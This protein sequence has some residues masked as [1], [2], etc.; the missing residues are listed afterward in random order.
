MKKIFTILC[1]MLLATGAFAELGYNATL[2][3]NDFNNSKTV[4]KKQGTIEWDGDHVRCGGSSNGI[5]LG[6]PSWDWDDKYFDVKIAN[7][8]PNKLTFEWAC[9]NVTSTQAD[10]YVKESADGT[11]WSAAIWETTSSTF[12]WTSVSKDLQPNTRY[13]R[14]CFSGNFAGNFRNIKVTEKILMGTPNPTALD[15]GTVKVDDEAALS[16]TLGWTNLTAT[17]TGTTDQFT[18]TP[19]NFG[20]IGA[21]TQ[22]ATISVALNTSAAGEYSTT[23]HVEGRGKSADVPVTAK[24]EKY[25]QTINWDAAASYNYGEA[26][27]VAVATSGLDVVYEISDASVLKFENGAFVALHGG[28]ATVTAKQAGNYKYNA[29]ADVVKT[30]T[31]V[32]PTT[33]GDFEQTT[34]DEAVEFKNQTY[35]ESFSGEVPVGENYLGGDSIVHVNIVINHATFGTD[36]MTIVYGDEVEWNGIALKDSTVGVHSAVAVLTN[37]AGCDST[38]TLT[39][40]VNKMDTLKV[41]TAFAFC[42][43]GSEEFHGKTYTE[44]IKDTILAIGETRDTL[45][46]VNVTV[47]QPSFVEEDMTIIVGTDTAWNGI[48][49]KDSTVGVHYVVFDTTNVAGCD[50]TVTLTLTVNKMDTLEVYYPIGFCAGDSAEYRGK[51]Y[52]E[53]GEDTILVEDA[54]QDTLIYVTIAVLPTNLSELKADTLYVGDTLFIE[55]D[56]WYLGETLVA[57]TI[58]VPT[59]AGEFDL[60]QTLKNES[61]CDSVIIRHIVVETKPENPTALDTVGAANKAAKVLRDGVIYIRREGKEFTLD[62]RVVK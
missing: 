4:V 57:D 56:T 11:N 19:E 51:W 48:A 55:A 7:G 20:Q 54:I 39:L 9:N 36:E 50:S 14:F 35:E 61:L 24:V 44:A 42:E 47:L 22:T 58:I 40:T 59:E 12:S 33:Y 2:T 26:I 13:I 25:D 8:V 3:Q 1:G 37:A 5:S 46:F 16:F 60:T 17:V 29:A 34:C 28:E 52:Y 31:I 6:G 41:D 43:G 30:I 10:W 21:Y 15:F 32:P 23:V 38:V 45:Y 53:S 27:P 49:L 18:V 62:G